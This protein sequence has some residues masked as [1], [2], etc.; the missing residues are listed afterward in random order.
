MA[1][2][3][4][5]TN[6]NDFR[7][8]KFTPNQGQ[9]SFTINNGYQ[10]G[11]IS[12]FRNGV[13]LTDGIDFTASDGSNVILNTG[14]DLGDDLVIEVLDTF[15]VAGVDAAVGIQSSGSSIGNAKTLNFVGTGNTFS[16]SGNTIDISI[17]SGGATGGGTDKVFQENQRVV[18]TN[19]TLSAGYSAMSV[20]PVT[21]SAGA[22]VTV[23][24][25]ERW[26]VL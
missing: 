14:C 19:Y 2:G 6:E 7:I 10:V 4:P 23:P 12:V 24:G 20:G 16:V 18:N 5:I 9:T 21:I 22:T 17:S 3:N 25:S 8:N 26:V 1:I 13:R 11:K 15:S